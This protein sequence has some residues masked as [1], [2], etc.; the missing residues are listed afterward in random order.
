MAGGV[1]GGVDPGAGREADAGVVFA[2]L[3]PHPPV[4]VPAVG[5]EA[6]A[7]VR[8]TA[9]ALERL[10]EG[11]A[12]SGADALAVVTPHGPV[13]AE[14]ACLY[15]GDRLAGDFAA[16]GAPEAAVAVAVDRD[17]SEAV[18]AEA[19][20]ANLPVLA[21][22][23]DGLDHGTLVPLYFLQEA[24]A[25]RP[26]VV[27]TPPWRLPAARRLG[28]VLAGAARRAR[29]RLALVASGDLSHRLK[30]G[31]PGGYAPE[32]RAFDER[33][34]ALLRAGDAEGVLE[35]PDVLAEAAGQ[36][37]LPGLAVL[38]GALAGRDARPEVLS[39]EGPFGVGYAVAVWRM[40]GA[41][42]EP[43]PVRAA[44]RALELYL[45]ERVDDPGEIARR[46]AAEVAGE[47]D[48][49]GPSR[50]V[51]VS[52]K[53][54]GEL[55]GCTGTIGPTRETLLE[56][57]V[58]AALGSAERDPRFPPVRPDELDDLDVSVDV[59][60][61]PEP[62]SGPEE[63]DP[64]RYG[65]IVAKGARRGLLLPDLPGITRPG[66]QYALACRKAGLDPDDPG[67]AVYRFRARRHR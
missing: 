16:F 21:V 24:G 54:G 1:S 31:A 22:R 62:V 63:L 14:A 38:L 34:V 53:E 65:V 59:L 30:P 32:G 2:A 9:A 10:A 49:L 57:I 33:L 48:L 28:R 4:L 64:R 23:P 58:H 25:L 15:W 43:A 56:E 45:R 46:L 51:F 36:D 35:F 37:V 19:E 39:Y 44:R 50:G 8:E 20:G 67:V 26:A 7:E 47:A 12:G 42:R 61:P 66:Q 55:R 29:R 27:L 17:L 41:R 11:L 40:R 13:R 5:G 6:V 3:A 52:L 18:L 60:E